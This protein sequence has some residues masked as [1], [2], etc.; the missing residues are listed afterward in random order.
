MFYYDSK[1]KEKYINAKC[2]LVNEHID[3]IKE[4]Q[5]W[6]NCKFKGAEKIIVEFN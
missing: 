2:L 5:L 4:G 1:E 6:S 3:D